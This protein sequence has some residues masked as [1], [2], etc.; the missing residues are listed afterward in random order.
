MGTRNVGGALPEPNITGARDGTVT[1]YKGTKHSS[2][3]CESTVDLTEATSI[4]YLSDV[5]APTLNRDKTAFGTS[6][7]VRCSNSLRT[8]A[9]G[10]LTS[11]GKSIEMEN[12][13]GSLETPEH[14][15]KHPVGNT[16]SENSE[17]RVRMVRFIRGLRSGTHIVNLTNRPIEI[18]GT[19]SF[20]LGMTFVATSERSCSVKR[21]G[22]RATESS[23]E[24]TKFGDTTIEK[25]TENVTCIDT[26]TGRLINITPYPIVTVYV[27]GYDTDSKTSDEH[28]KKIL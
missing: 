5:T 26:V 13:T 14:L 21:M 10:G 24:D 20:G 27:V 18:T 6:S 7:V 19:L 22:E 17:S 1:N 23:K 8:P 4:V 12:R 2:R 25:L 3:L 28:G 11:L 9:L 16:S 15:G